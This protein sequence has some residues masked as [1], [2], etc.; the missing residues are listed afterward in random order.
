MDPPTPY[1]APLGPTNERY[2]LQ[3]GGSESYT[4]IEDA[5]SLGGM[6]F[7]RKRKKQVDGQTCPLCQL[8][9][10]EDAA[11]C[12]R[13]YYE[14]TVAAHRQT[15]SEL[16]D[17][18]SGGLFDALMEEEEDSD[19]ES[20]M[21]D[22][23]S[24]SFSMDD[25][26]VEVSP[27]DSEGI[28]EVDQTVS[29]DHQFDAPQQVARVKGQEPKQEDEE[30]VLTSADTPKNVEKFDTG[31]GPDLEYQ[32][33][34]YSAPVVKLVEMTESDDIA[35]VASASAIPD[36]SDIEPS[37]EPVSTPTQVTQTEPVKTE[38]IAT[39]VIPEVPKVPE[40]PTT[41]VA[42]TIP[43]IPPLPQNV[44]SSETPSI[45]EVPTPVHTPTPAPA[46]MWPWPQSDAWDDATVRKSLRDAMESAKSG[47]IDASKRALVSL[48][49]H[50]GDRVDLIFHVG[51]LL[52]KFEQEDVM[53]RMIENARIQYPDSPD[54][55]KAVQHLLS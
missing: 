17:E 6:M 15:V 4:R 45:P 8:V 55:A 32:E 53:R 18:D 13:C 39:P 54:V 2:Q 14:F 44:D 41:P 46:G 22:W 48:G 9:N 40:I 28:V 27:Y 26:T 47:D 43:E 38:P 50:L 5:I 21:V 20:P 19:D 23:T 52:K 24:H 25:M 11:S 42:P 37:P 34:E 10:A 30:Y 16:S 1:L 49:P 3:A 35:P 7:G 12:T 36:E 29:M 51:V 33:E 31:D